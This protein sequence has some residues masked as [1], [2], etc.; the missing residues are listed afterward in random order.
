VRGP[1]PMAVAESH[2]SS[3]DA[4][5]PAR[6]RLAP[7][8]A[9]SLEARARFRLVSR[10]VA[11]QRFARPCPKTRQRFV[12]RLDGPDP[13]GVNPEHAPDVKDDPGRAGGAWGTIDRR[14]DAGR[15]RRPSYSTPASPVRP[16][17]LRAGST[18]EPP[19]SA[20]AAPPS[21]RRAGP[22]VNGEGGGLPPSVR[23]AG[24]G[25]DGEGGGLPPSV[26]RAGQGVDGEGD[27]VVVDAVVGDEADPP[28][29]DRAG[30]DA[31]RG[32]VIE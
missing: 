19:G 25:V 28:G 3:G 26:R 17:I 16:D 8:A 15:C 12:G 30:Q 10:L 22:G 6:A 5:R 11:R 4:P 24:Q 14:Q 1:L 27:G 18:R 31:V 29:G 32:E 9:G 23:R 13:I 7:P 20:G 2:E 21:V